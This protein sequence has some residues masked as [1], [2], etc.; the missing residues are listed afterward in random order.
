[1]TRSHLAMLSLASAMFAMGSIPLATPE[2]GR[3]NGQT[4]YNP[5]RKKNKDEIQKIRTI[6]RRMGR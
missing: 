1:M 5:K 6:R 3:R 2:Y 4:K